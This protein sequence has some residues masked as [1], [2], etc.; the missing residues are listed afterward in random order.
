MSS[1]GVC[2]PH[3]SLKGIFPLQF[4]TI[5][6]S[7]SIGTQGRC[8]TAA[9]QGMF[10]NN[11]SSQSRNDKNPLDNVP[12]LANQAQAWVMKGPRD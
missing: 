7:T 8:K 4:Q 11:V 5:S 3:K 1:S 6:N 10:A 12:S 9:T 2:I